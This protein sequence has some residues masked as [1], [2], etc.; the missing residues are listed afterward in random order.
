MKSPKCHE[1]INQL[2]TL[3]LSHPRYAPYIN[4]TTFRTFDSYNGV[5]VTL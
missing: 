2:S 3:Y 5:Q 4:D 1:H